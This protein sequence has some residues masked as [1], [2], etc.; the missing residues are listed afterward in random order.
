[1]KKQSAEVIKLTNQL[2]D[3]MSDLSRTSDKLKLFDREL[4]KERMRHDAAKAL[5]E[6]WRLRAEEL[7]TEDPDEIPF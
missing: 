2:G 4:C 1:M 3:V 7:A 6:Y 5:V